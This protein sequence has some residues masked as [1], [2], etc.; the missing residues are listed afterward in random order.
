[1]YP[2]FSSLN[3]THVEMIEKLKSTAHE[4]K[5]SFDAFGSIIST[6]PDAAGQLTVSSYRQSLEPAPISPIDALP[7]H[8]LAGT[9]R[10]TWGTGKGKDSGEPIFVAPGMMSGMY[11]GLLE[12]ILKANITATLSF[13]R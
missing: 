5:L 11:H 13:N 10:K 4:L 2:L 12:Q 9:I 6:E 8:L 1:M 3:A 7:Y